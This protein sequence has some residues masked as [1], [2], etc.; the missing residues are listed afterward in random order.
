MIP[1]IFGTT[2]I[3]QS[4]KSYCWTGLSGFVSI[5]L[6]VRQDGY[7]TI[8][9]G[10]TLIFHEFQPGGFLPPPHSP[11]LRSGNAVSPRLKSRKITGLSPNHGQITI[12]SDRLQFVGDK[13]G[14]LPI[15]QNKLLLHN[16]SIYHIPLITGLMMHKGGQFDTFRLGSCIDSFF[17]NLTISINFASSFDSCHVQA[18]NAAQNIGSKLGVLHFFI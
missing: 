16:S 5:L 3:E 18:N 2:D 13:L 9:K 4:W 11:M 8:S 7:L 12:L 17:Q 14:M 6:T 15:Q 1:E 10:F